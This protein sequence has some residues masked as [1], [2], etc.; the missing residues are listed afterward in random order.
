M[1]L[2]KKKYQ[3]TGRESLKVSRTQY[4]YQMLNAVE[5]YFYF[6]NLRIHENIFKFLY[7]RKA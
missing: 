1:L 4:S 3:M 2:F 5:D 6:S 7:S